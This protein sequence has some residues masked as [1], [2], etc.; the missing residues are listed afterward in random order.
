MAEQELND[1]K[2]LAQ[3]ITDDDRVRHS[4]PPM[5]WDNIQAAI[6]ES[7]PLPQR[8]TEDGNV[9][10]APVAETPS[11]SVVP[12]AEDEIVP[13]EDVIDLSAARE[14]NAPATARKTRRH[15]ILAGAASLLA[16]VVGLSLFN[17]DRTPTETL[18]ASV[19]NE[20]LP[21]AY[22]GTATASLELDDAPM[23]E[24]SFDA[25]LPT[26]EPVE[27]WLIKP[28]LSDMRSLGIVQP[29]D[30]SWDW[31]DDLDPNEYSIVDLSI[32]PN[33]GDPTHSG[34]SILRGQLTDM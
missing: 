29:G 12:E 21:E 4:P 15:L 28:D 34:R 1:W 17:I 20:T 31:P 11:L 18:V 32:E 14:R 19:S 16:V 30:T 6:A 7:E 5:V 9:M 10:T 8:P 23:L 25:A 22:D 13:Q 3:S 24:I 33:D 27:L 2:A 26:D